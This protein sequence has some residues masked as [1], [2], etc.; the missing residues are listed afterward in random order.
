MRGDPRPLPR[1]PTGFP[2][3]GLLQSA[4]GSDGCERGGP[5]YLNRMSSPPRILVLDDNPADLTLLD[6]AVAASGVA[7]SVTTCI[8]ASDALEL[9]RRD[10]DFALIL[11]DIN[12][13]GIN[14]IEFLHAVTVMPTASTIPIALM[15][16]SA[17][18]ALPSALQDP[19]GQLPYFTKPSDWPGFLALARALEQASR[20]CSTSEDAGEA[21]GARIWPS[22]A[23]A[24][25]SSTRARQ[26]EDC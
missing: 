26:T 17:R 16:S 4:R 9:L 24:S 5:S 10:G 18:D 1:V 21:L 23:G 11:S 2:Y 19:L 12:M 3:E 7:L 8:R 6:E 14:G 22:S 13:P 20:T 15:S 25:T